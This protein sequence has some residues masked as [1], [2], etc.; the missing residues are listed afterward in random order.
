MKKE[1]KSE[2]V[3]FAIAIIVET[4]IFYVIIA[5]SIYDDFLNDPDNFTFFQ[6]FCGTIFILL[7]PS[8]LLDTVLKF[9]M[10]IFIP[11][12]TFIVIRRRLSK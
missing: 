11:L 7:K 1:T 8:I 6:V 9:G 4:F 10:L 3:A 12:L 5:M 2:L